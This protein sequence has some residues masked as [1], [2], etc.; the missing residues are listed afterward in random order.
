MDRRVF[1]QALASLGLSNS[2]IDWDKAS[3]IQVGH[4][5]REVKQGPLQVIVSV[6]GRLS[7]SRLAGR[8]PAEDSACSVAAPR[9]RAEQIAHWFFKQLGKDEMQERLGVELVDSDDTFHS[10]CFAQ[11]RPSFI[12]EANTIAAAVGIPIQFKRELSAAEK[13]WEQQVRSGKIVGMDDPVWMEMAQERL[14]T[15]LDTHWLGTK[16]E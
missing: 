4:A 5:W 16:G 10:S 7:L 8:E 13:A 2:E 3:D 9:Y 1:L 6:A 15:A 11:L 12:D 14:D